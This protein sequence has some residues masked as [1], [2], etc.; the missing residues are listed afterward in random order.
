[1]FLPMV[2]V[3]CVPL[4]AFWSVAVVQVPQGELLA[5]GVV[6][7]AHNET[8]ATL[9]PDRQE[10]YFT[11]GDLVSADTTIL[12]A[13]Y[14]GQRYRDVR[15]APFS[16]IWKDSEPHLSPDGQR[17]FFVSNRPVTPRQ[18][19]LIATRGA[20]RF[21]GAN[22]WYVDKRG[23]NWGE[24]IHISGEIAGTP[25]VYNPSVAA[26]GHLYFSAHRDDSG[27]GYQIYMAKPESQGWSRPHQVLL[28]KGV[29]ANHMDPAIDPR[30]RFIL[31]AGDEGDSAGSADIY[32]A[33]RM[34]NGAW[35]K[36]VRLPD[37]VN[38]MY[39]EN[40]PTLG[41]KF[42][43]LFVTSMR[44]PPVSFPKTAQDM[45]ALQRRLEAPLNGSR[46]IWRFDIS[47]L[48]RQHGI[49]D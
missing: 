1:M 3:M 21:P 23:K 12:L 24:P 48:L 25:M 8:S 41:R 47:A 31:F 13:H 35:G 39:L 20:M 45:P 5:P 40:A 33:F 38:S 14:D 10:L 30:E 26:N 44:T 6:S 19:A 4:A 37:G 18:P 36:P 29:K 15:I 43:E 46:N 42:G 49:H 32:I 9:S 16:G 11:R 34:P 27:A 2:M 7:T 28:G 22:L 17:L